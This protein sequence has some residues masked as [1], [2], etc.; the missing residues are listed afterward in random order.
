M[1]PLESAPENWWVDKEDRSHENNADHE[2]NVDVGDV[3]DFQM[4]MDVENDKKSSCKEEEE[5]VF[6]KF[7]H[8]AS[9]ATKRSEKK[10]KERTTLSIDQS[11]FPL[12]ESMN[13]FNSTL[14]EFSCSPIDLQSL[15]A[16]TTTCTSKD[17]QTTPMCQQFDCNVMPSDLKGSM[18]SPPAINPSPSI[19]KKDQTSYSSR[20]SSGLTQESKMKASPGPITLHCTSRVSFQ[21]QPRVILLNP[22]STLSNEHT[23]CLR[24]CVNDGFI[25]ILKT[26]QQQPLCASDYVDEFESDLTLTLS[27]V[28]NPS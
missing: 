16:D 25:S 3:I 15:Q 24:K 21:T 11:L 26:Q 9:N 18:N 4:I 19:A 6:D 7:L 12:S 17:Q 22:S 27:T 8:D 28:D 10:G 13:V 1:F 23:C 20:Q 14:P 2:S 5:A